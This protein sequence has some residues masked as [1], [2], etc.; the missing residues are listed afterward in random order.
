[1][2]KQFHVFVYGDVIGVGFRAWT[3]IQAINLG[4]DGWVRNIE[5]RVEA[6]IQ[7]EEKTLDKMLSHLRT[8]PPV[9]RVDKIETNEEKIKETFS[10]F[11][12]RK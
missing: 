9:S 12:I 6:I 8:G 1:M 5:D 10:S 11:E 7:G 3:K 4:I 2:L